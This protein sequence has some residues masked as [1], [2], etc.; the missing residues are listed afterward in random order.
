MAWNGYRYQ[1]SETRRLAAGRESKTS[2]ILE[3][4]IGIDHKKR[5]DHEEVKV[6]FNR[7]AAHKNKKI[8][9]GRERD[10]SDDAPNVVVGEF[11]PKQSRDQRSC[12]S[13]RQDAPS[14]AQTNDAPSKRRR[15]IDSQLQKRVRKPKQDDG[16]K[17]WH[18][19][20]VTIN[21]STPP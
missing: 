13:Y 2:D 3:P 5:H 19:R 21:R 6:H 8:R 20:I 15:K 10:R 18:Q 7:S 4:P 14:P 11:A 16:A 1:R 9:I 17:K 12:P